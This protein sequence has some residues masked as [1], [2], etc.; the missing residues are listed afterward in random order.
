MKSFA[1]AKEAKAYFLL[2]WHFLALCSLCS[3]AP[4]IL[5]FALSPWFVEQ[6]AEANVKKPTAHEFCQSG[7]LLHIWCAPQ[8]GAQLNR[9]ESKGAKQ[10]NES[11][12]KKQ[13]KK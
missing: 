3:F 4:L 5:F 2:L 12:N 11:A 7:W 13:R 6:R 9:S 8:S 1:E 10:R